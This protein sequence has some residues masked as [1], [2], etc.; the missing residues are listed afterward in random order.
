MHRPAPSALA[1]VLSLCVSA[2]ARG[3]PAS[4]QAPVYD[5]V[6]A[7]VNRQVITLSELQFEAR[8]ALLQAGGPEAL[9][10]P[11][12]GPLLRS[13][14]E[15]VIGQRLQVAEAE[16]LQAFSVE[17]QEVDAAVYALERRAGGAAAL[18]GI[19]SRSDLDPDALS[20]VVARRIRAERALDGKLRLKAQVSDAEVRRAWETR[21]EYRARPLEEA[22]PEL[23]DRLVRE[24]YRELAAAELQRLRRAADVRVV[25]GP[26]WQGTP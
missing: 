24:R 14:L 8:V 11:L 22:R 2:H 5:R 9:A 23:R 6:V 20:A 12:D 1:L 19:L 7:V 4:E 10:T 3:E 17:P 15:Y 26:A 13:T 25:D 16:K 21:P 18:R